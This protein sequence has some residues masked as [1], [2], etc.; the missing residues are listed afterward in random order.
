MTFLS[1]DYVLF[2]KVVGTAPAIGIIVGKRGTFAPLY[3][4]I[5]ATGTGRALSFRDWEIVHLDLYES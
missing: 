5:F 2:K 4:V 3:D 1:G